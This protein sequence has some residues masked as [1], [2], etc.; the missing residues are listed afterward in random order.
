[1]YTNILYTDGCIRTR[2]ESCGACIVLAQ[3]IG[4]KSNLLTV[5]PSSHGHDRHA[6]IEDAPA[7]Y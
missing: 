2:R 7:Q 5:L 4:T 3:R 6:V 1:M